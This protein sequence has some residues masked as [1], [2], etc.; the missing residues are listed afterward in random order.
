MFM[1]AFLLTGNLVAL[2]TVDD[3]G[4]GGDRRGDGPE[5]AAAGG[6]TSTV[7]EPTT[8]APTPPPSPTN[9]SQGATTTTTAPTTETTMF[10]QAST[11][12]DGYVYRVD[13]APTCAAIGEE[14]TITFY[15]KPRGGAILIATYADGNTYETWHAAFADENGVLVHKWRAPPAPGQGTVW[16][17]AA[18]R[19]TRRKGATNVNF[20]IA[21]P[22]ESC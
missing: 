22:G 4:A 5:L 13:L 21:K 9:R 2:A 11:L 20:H 8:T 19:E 12:A 16:T 3:A 1:V 17:Q 18:D 6:P 7:A 10:P 15:L 14:F